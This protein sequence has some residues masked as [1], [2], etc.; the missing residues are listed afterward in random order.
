MD[1]QKWT[2]YHIFS[3]IVIWKKPNCTLYMNILKYTICR[4][5]LH[6]LHVDVCV[7]LVS[8]YTRWILNALTQPPQHKVGKLVLGCDSKKISIHVFVFSCNKINSTFLLFIKFFVANKYYTD[9][10]KI[11][12]LFKMFRNRGAHKTGFSG[13]LWAAIGNQPSWT[14]SAD[15]AANTYN[16]TFSTC[17]N[18]CCIY[19]RPLYW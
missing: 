18:Y 13:W 17:Q 5:Y 7:C 3:K 11:E 19:Y 14:F 12:S 4:C 9:V 6:T 15:T 8:M 1:V 2:K 10:Q 16:P